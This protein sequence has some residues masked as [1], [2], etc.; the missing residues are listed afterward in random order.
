MS[1]EKSCLRPPPFQKILEPQLRLLLNSLPILL[2][3]PEGTPGYESYWQSEYHDHDT[4][5]KDEM[6][7]FYQTFS[8]MGVAQVEQSLKTPPCRFKAFDVIEAHVYNHADNF[9]V[10]KK[11]FVQNILNKMIIQISV[12]CCP[13]PFCPTSGGRGVVGKNRTQFNMNIYI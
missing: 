9:Q 12:A 10:K 3:L 8:R 11:I 13:Q 6:V 5:M 7:T 2:F 1:P 4:E